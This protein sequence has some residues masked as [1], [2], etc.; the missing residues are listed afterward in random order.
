M[1]QISQP[2]VEVKY[3]VALSIPFG[4][5]PGGSNSSNLTLPCSFNSFWDA[6]TLYFHIT[7]P[8]ETVF[9]FL[10]GCYNGQP[11]E[12]PRN[13]KHSFNSFWDATTPDTVVGYRSV[14]SFQFLLGCYWLVAPRLQHFNVYSARGAFNSFWDATR[15]TATIF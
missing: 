3:Y 1:L 10:L 9:Q 15:C 2:S 5:L 6:T 8:S 14:T 7:N 4:M 13:D 12:N 11:R